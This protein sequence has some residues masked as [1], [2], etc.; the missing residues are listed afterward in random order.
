M[1]ISQ[2]CG[3]VK[4]YYE[5]FSAGD[6][7]TPGLLTS[8]CSSSKWVT[9]GARA[10]HASNVKTRTHHLRVNMK[11]LSD[12]VHEGLVVMGIWQ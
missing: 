8:S 12:S 11:T 3:G 7:L 10:N 9:A 2:V 6:E 4:W 5:E 1:D